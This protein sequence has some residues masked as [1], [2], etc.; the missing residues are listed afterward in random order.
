[1]GITDTSFSFTQRRE[2]LS[3]LLGATGS[4]LMC[5]D[6]KGSATS[7]KD[8]HLL[9]SQIYLWVR[10]LCLRMKQQFPDQIAS[11]FPCAAGVATDGCGTLHH[12]KSTWHD[13]PGGRTALPNAGVLS[14]R[15]LTDKRTHFS[16]LKWCFLYKTGKHF[17]CLLRFICKYAFQHFGGLEYFTSGKYLI[18]WDWSNINHI[19]STLN[20][21]QVF[22]ADI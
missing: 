22:S 4:S 7:R 6:E 2:C 20:R 10:I 16:R 8:F 3:L 5:R 19:K 14:F 18:W 1:M 13:K 21:S 12:A 9:S 11:P 17:Q 15:S